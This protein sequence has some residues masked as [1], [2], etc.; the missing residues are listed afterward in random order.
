M[1][2]Q[3]LQTPW[4]VV[5]HLFVFMLGC[6]PALMVQA[7]VE[8]DEWQVPYEKSRPRDP[9]AAQADEVWFV[10]QRTGYL[11]RFDLT[12]ESFEL[13]ELK[14]GS[15]PHNLIVGS[16]GIVWFAGNRTALI[17]R[18][19][20][21]SGDLKEIAMP[22]AAVKDPHTL[23]FD[24]DES[25][26]WFTAQRSNRI[27]RLTIATQKVDLIPVPSADARPYG[28]KVGPGGDIWVDLFGTNKLAHVDPQSLELTEIVLPR[29]NS[30]PRRLEI[31]SDGRVWYGDYTGG[32]LGVYDPSSESIQE[33]MLPQGETA[34]PY[35][36]ASDSEDR[37]WLVATGV[38]P[39][40]FVGFDTR[41]ETFTAA[42]PIPSGAGTVR[43]M[44]YHP[45][46]QAV[47]F[48]T[49]SNYL[50]RAMLPTASGD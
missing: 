28:I 32:H 18:Y 30:R 7:Q 4:M 8:I 36:M 33:W 3:T 17:G 44:H 27:G 34:A 49:D 2:Q 12:T 10:G 13:V 42:T 24:A 35:G 29:A 25:H 15:G 20:P 45:E 31:T 5:R 39:N 11:A 23:V 14:E 6:G 46:S 41:T 50:G 43:H 22:D 37:I 1:K 26:I 21:D 9:F 19:D 48:G 16:D 47:W 38:Y 40:E